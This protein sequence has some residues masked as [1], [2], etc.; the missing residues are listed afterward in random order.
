MSANKKPRN[1]A[2][3]PR[4]VNIPMMATTRNSLAL[5]LHLMIE[6]LIEAP[7]PDTYN[8]LSKK[9]AQLVYTGAQGKCLDMATD[10]LTAVCDRFERVGRVGTSEL[11]AK[12]LRMAGV[13]LDS[14]LGTIPINKVEDAGARVSIYAEEMGV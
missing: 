6:A 2:H 9:L 5:K 11:E 12:A 7:S 8:Q 14:L 3:K 4:A 10:V 1:K 13:G